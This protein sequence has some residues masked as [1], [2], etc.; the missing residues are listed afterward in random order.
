M[1]SN[2]KYCS[3][4]KLT[5]T[6]DEFHKNKIHKCGL[7]VHCKTCR[8]MYSVK[9]YKLNK[10]IISAKNKS[11]YKNNK[12][13]RLKKSSE[14]YFN[15]KDR[16]LKRQNIYLIEKRKTDIKF[17]LKF[18]LRIRLNSALKGKNKSLSTMFLIG[19][20]IDY[21]MYHLQSQF[22]PGMTWDSYGKKGWVIDHIKPCSS[23]DLTKPEE[24]EKCF[25]Y[26][27]LQPLWAK[28]NLSKSSKYDSI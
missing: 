17:R 24:Q 3:A 13:R 7:H 19:C 14:W 1:K 27:N 8:R 21:L 11:W 12:I 26:T 5:K 15:N 9:N 10:K 2:Y 22:K 18:N 16:V 6:F 23:F 25:H 20:E 28:D 4:C